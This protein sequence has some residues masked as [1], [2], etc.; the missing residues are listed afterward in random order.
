MYTS[1]MRAQ[2][3]TN[4]GY[5]WQTRKGEKGER[6]GRQKEQG[7]RMEEGEEEG[8]G[9]RMRREEGLSR[10]AR[11]KCCHDVLSR[12]VHKKYVKSVGG[13]EQVTKHVAETDVTLAFWTPKGHDINLF[14]M[15]M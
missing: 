4:Y 14:Y 3:L 9:E 12:N 6:K 5:E 10:S 8:E 13:L 11:T 7:R 2:A 1:D 15:Q